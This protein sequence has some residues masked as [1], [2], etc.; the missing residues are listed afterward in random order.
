MRYSWLV[1]LGEVETRGVHTGVTD[2]LP[3]FNVASF[4]VNFVMVGARHAP[5]GCAGQPGRGEWSV[6]PSVQAP[7]PPSQP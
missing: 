3:A 1:V 6:R 4:G 7:A 5:F 2:E